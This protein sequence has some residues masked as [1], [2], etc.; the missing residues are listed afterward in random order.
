MKWAWQY[1]K[2]VEEPL[3]PV[4][5]DT[6]YQGLSRVDWHHFL[7][8]LP[9]TQKEQ[10]KLKVRPPAGYVYSFVCFKAFYP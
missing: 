8:L 3:S 6:F 2:T 4:S 5:A 9:S 7:V 10:E 1:G